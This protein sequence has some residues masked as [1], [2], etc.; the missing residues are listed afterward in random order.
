MLLLP[1]NKPELYWHRG[2]GFVVS[3]LGEHSLVP[4]VYT[5]RV[6]IIAKDL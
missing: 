5:F 6:G 4:A 1:V 3:S 2:H